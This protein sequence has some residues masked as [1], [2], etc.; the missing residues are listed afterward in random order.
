MK[1]LSRRGARP[2][3]EPFRDDFDKLVETMFG[4]SF[5]GRLPAALSASFVPPMDVSETD[6]AWLVSVQLPGM[7]EKDIQVELR[8]NL[9]TIRGE[10]TWSE[11]KKD[12]QVHR[13]ESQYGSFQRTLTLPTTVRLE[14]NAV[15]ARYARGVLELTIPKIEPTPAVKIPV[16]AS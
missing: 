12:K 16:Q 10:R 3:L 5:A 1:L 13:V 7:E 11:E 4:E 2:E 8:G 6:K 9:L 14:P 15:S